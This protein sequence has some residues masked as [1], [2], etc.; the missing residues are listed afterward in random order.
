MNKA[1]TSLQ[2]LK[3]IEI[4]ER[5]R[6]FYARL[7]AR[8]AIGNNNREAKE[9]FLSCMKDQ[10]LVLMKRRLATPII[11]EE[12]WFVLEAMVKG[13]TPTLDGVIVE[14]FLCKWLVI[15]KEYMKM[16]EDFIINDNFPPWVTRRLITLLHKGGEK[17][18]LPNRRPN[19]LLNITYKIFV[20]AL[21][22]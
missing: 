19:T 7:Y 5:C 12:L 16:I 22:M 6:N 17:K 20:K 2:L 8:Q 9:G 1:K 10:I 18:Q 11:K 15:G 14:F 3:Y 13:K 4:G 21:Q